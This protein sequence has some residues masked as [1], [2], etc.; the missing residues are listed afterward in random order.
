MLPSS[1]LLCL[2]HSHSPI[3]HFGD[4][5]FSSFLICFFLLLFM[6]LFQILFSRYTFS[7]FPFSP[8]TTFSLSHSQFSDLHFSHILLFLLSSLLCN[9]LIFSFP[10]TFS[11]LIPSSLSLTSPSPPCLMSS[12]QFAFP[13]LNPVIF[14]TIS[15]HTLAHFL[16]HFSPVLLF[17]FFSV[18]SWL[19]VS[20]CLHTLLI[21]LYLLIFLPIQT[22]SSL[23][24]CPVMPL[25]FHP[26]FH[27]QFLSTSS[28]QT[29]LT[30]NCVFIKHCQVAET[31]S[32]G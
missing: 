30:V 7:S 21:L 8:A 16:H 26:S 15:A 17:W 27:F 24:L 25:F 5:F 9:F 28:S 29:F 4:V 22:T 6:P 2:P 20:H 32:I 31:T 10:L 14:I 11:A 18:F 13:K 12:F 1:L 19:L 23:L 3:L